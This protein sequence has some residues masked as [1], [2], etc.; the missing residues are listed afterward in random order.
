MTEFKAVPAVEKTVRIL[1]I[2]AGASSRGM[3]VSDISA[4]LSY[5]KGTVY[6]ILQTLLVNHIVEKNLS[7]N[8][9]SLGLGLIQLA[10]S[11]NH[12]SLLISCFMEIGQEMS[13][14]CKENINLS[15]LRNGYNC[16]IASIPS[17]NQHILRVELPV[18]ELIPAI[19]SSS[20]KVLL[21][22]MADSEIRRIFENQ[23]YPYTES[24]ISSADEFIEIIH[25]VR[26]NGY[27][28]NNAEYGP[29]VCSV[30]APVFDSSR[31]IIAA[32]NIVI[33]QVRFTPEVRSELI[34]LV[35]ENARRLSR[36]IV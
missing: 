10:E 29:G 33:P 11:Y 13:A 28:V 23:Y 32:M 35:I 36:M 25:Q 34:A 27:A 15:Y 16:S 9:Y 12:R 30:S 6:S 31:S 20:G 3:G 18:G 24:T 8:K 26:E 2:L 5:S 21:S 19:S 17:V 4:A 1:Q 14:H 22:S 7:T